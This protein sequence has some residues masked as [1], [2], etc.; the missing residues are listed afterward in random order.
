MRLPYKNGSFG[1]SLHGITSA[2][3]NDWTRERAVNIVIKAFRAETS[4]GLDTG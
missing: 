4:Y 2:G 3:Y 1:G